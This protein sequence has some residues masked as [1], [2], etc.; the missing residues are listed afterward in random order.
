MN[1]IALQAVVLGHILGSPEVLDGIDDRDFADPKFREI[2]RDLKRGETESLK[3]WLNA[4]GVK[5]W[6]GN[7][8][9]IDAVFGTVKKQAAKQRANDARRAAKFLLS[10]D[11]EQIKRKLR[12][13]SDGI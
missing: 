8:K 7:G 13:L 11:P 2:I 4:N 6:S 5:W 3:A 12:E 1:N 10:G 9:A